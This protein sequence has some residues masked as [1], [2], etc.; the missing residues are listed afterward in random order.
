M[1]E[2]DQI[3]DL[4]RMTRYYLD[5]SYYRAPGRAEYYAAFTLACGFLGHDPAAG[6]AQ[7]AWERICDRHLKSAPEGG[8]PGS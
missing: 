3:A 5:R 7:E 6:V 1:T 2:N 4:I 8:G